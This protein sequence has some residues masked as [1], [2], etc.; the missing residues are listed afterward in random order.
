MYI[1]TRKATTMKTNTT[2]TNT[3]QKGK[4]T[5]MKTTNTKTTKRIEQLKKNNEKRKE[6]SKEKIIQTI[7]N[8]ESTVNKKA[9]ECVTILK[10]TQDKNSPE[11]TTCLY[12]LSSIIIQSKLKNINKDDKK[13]REETAQLKNE[14][15]QLFYHSTD[16]NNNTPLRNIYLNELNSLY[17]TTYNSNGDRVTKCT[18]KQKEKKILKDLE[19]LTRLESAEEILQD[20]VLK[21]WYYIEKELKLIAYDFGKLRTETLQECCLLKE[22]EKVKLHTTTYKNG[23]VKPVELWEK[24]FTN[25]IKESLQEVSRIIDSKKAVKENTIPYDSIET[26]IYNPLTEEEE[27]I[28]KYHKIPQ[29]AVVDTLDGN[30][31][32]FA[33]TAD[34]QTLNLIEKISA[35]ANFTNNQTYIFKQYFGNGKSITQLADKMKVQ[36]RY[37]KKELAN[38]KQK[39]VDTRIFESVGYTDEKAVDNSKKARKIACY[40][41]TDEQNKIFVCFFES[42]GK[43]NKSLLIDK[44]NISK[45]LKGSRKQVNGF[46][47]EYVTE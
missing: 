39:A 15:G 14:L 11:F 41:V 22:F 24:T 6:K 42:L 44:G 16:N 31:K 35:K 45:V 4:A 8:T 23:D 21:L 25:P 33:Q 19:N 46:C 43:A 5:T 2:T 27:T 29:I 9:V 7:N 47:F 10:E 3:T 20:I 26:T 32:Q 18:D 34:K 36:E 13:F 17:I 40:D 12:Q 37:I 38:I 1:S 28:I 30:G